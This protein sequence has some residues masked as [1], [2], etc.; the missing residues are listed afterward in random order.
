[1]ANVVTSARFQDAMDS[2]ESLPPDDQAVLVDVIRHRLAQTARARII[3]EVTEAK[4]EY[5][6]GNL[7]RGTVEALMAEIGE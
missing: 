2:V 5:A 3:A 6:Q 1:M 4:A 7:R